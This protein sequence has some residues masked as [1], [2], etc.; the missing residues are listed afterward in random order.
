MNGEAPSEGTSAGK[1]QRRFV[2][3]IQG[4]KLRLIKVGS[5]RCVIRRLRLLQTGSPDLLDI[6]GVME[7]EDAWAKEAELLSRWWAHRWHGEW[8]APAPEILAYIAEHAPPKV[9]AKRQALINS[10]TTKRLAAA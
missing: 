3:F 1:R 4:A 5:A 10:A 6:I 8:F 2:Y 7:P 9:D